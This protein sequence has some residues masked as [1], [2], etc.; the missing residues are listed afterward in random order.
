MSNPGTRIIGLVTYELD[1]RVRDAL[2]LG[3]AAV[4]GKDQ[5]SQSLVNLIRKVS[6]PA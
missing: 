4:L 3:A 2:A 6:R 5:L 1:D